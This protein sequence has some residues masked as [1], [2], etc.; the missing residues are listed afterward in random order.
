MNITWLGQGGFLFES[1]TTRL[2]VDPYLS[3]FVERNHHLTRLMEP[4]LSVEQLR[5]SAVFCTHDHI[6]HLDPEGAVWLAEAYPESRFFGPDSVVRKLGELGL[7]HHSAQAVGVG[8]TVSIGDFTVTATPAKH[9]DPDAVGLIV[10]D[11][12]RLLY[13]SGDTEFTPDLAD[14]VADLASGPLDAVL[15]CINGRM[16]NMKGEEAVEVVKALRPAV[17]HP[18]HY[19]L[20]A[21]NTAAPQPFVQAVRSAGIEAGTMTPGVAFTLTG[22]A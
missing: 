12:E 17:A 4:P 19:G 22:R 8:Q 15:I 21:E 9:S 18:M 1:G 10:S 6:D 13:L 20:F 2:V 7:A 5:P 16:G 3:D 14:Q 11:S